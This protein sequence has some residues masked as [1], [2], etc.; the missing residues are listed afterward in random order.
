MLRQRVETVETLSRA[1]FLHITRVG[2]HLE[3]VYLIVV[4]PTIGKHEM[5]VVGLTHIDDTDVL[6]VQ[7]MHHRLIALCVE[8]DAR[9][10]NQGLNNRILNATNVV[11]T[12]VSHLQCAVSDVGFI[13]KEHVVERLSCTVHFVGFELERMR[14]PRTTPASAHAEAYVLRELMLARWREE[15]EKDGALPIHVPVAG[16]SLTMSGSAVGAF[17]HHTMLVSIEEIGIAD[18]R[19]HGNGIGIPTLDERP[20]DDLARQIAVAEEAEAVVDGSAHGEVETLIACSV[21]RRSGDATGQRRCG[22]VGRIAKRS[23]FRS[24]HG[25]R[26]RTV[27]DLRLDAHLGQWQLGGHLNKVLIRCGGCGL[28]RQK[29]LSHSI[30]GTRVGCSADGGRIRL[31]QDELTLRVVEADGSTVDIEFE[32]HLMGR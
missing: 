18:N 32:R 8:V 13:S 15:R 5:L 24:R 23:T 27:D 21:L 17:H 30:D 11:V 2:V 28:A 29:P 19:E 1:T 3:E 7:I 22:T 31:R 25:K 12:T 9:A 6:S 4:P 20:R 16:F 10:Q 26:K 14:I